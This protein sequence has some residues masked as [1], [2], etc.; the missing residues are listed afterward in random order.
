MRKRKWLLGSFSVCPRYS[1]FWVG[2]CPVLKG[3]G[4][5]VI[6]T[7]ALTGEAAEQSLQGPPKTPLLQEGQKWY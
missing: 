2:S 7:P 3:G 1:L 6:P 5:G 4:Q